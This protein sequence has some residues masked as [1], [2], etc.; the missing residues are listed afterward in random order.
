MFVALTDPEKG[1]YDK[2]ASAL[3]L[4]PSRQALSSAVADVA[5]DGT[6]DT[7]TFYFAGHGGVSNGA[8]AL[9]CSDTDCDRFIATALPM[10]EIFQILND[11]QPRHSYIIIDACQAAGMVADIGNLLRPSQQGMAHSASVSIFASCAADRHAEESGEGGVGTRHVL[12]CIE[13]RT[14]CRVAKE[15]L[16]L[17]DIGS[18]VSDE[19]GDQSPSVWSFNCSGASKFVKNPRASSDRQKFS[20]LPEFGSSVLSK[21][22]LTNSEQLWRLYVDASEEIEVRELQEQLQNVI[23]D[24]DD[25]RD[26]AGLIVGLSES[27]SSRGALSD[28]SFASLKSS[29][30]SY[31]LPKRLKTL[32]SAA[33]CSPTS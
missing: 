3:L 10:T 9:C 11:A 21:I 31:L 12:D 19:F 22:K 20:S 5:Y 25:S 33:K 16:S 30:H 2:D 1:E 6:I 14:D 7:F 18:V 17:D 4:D 29:V 15:H 28:D 24:L 23:R 13:G 26:Q 8:F 32:R 27:F